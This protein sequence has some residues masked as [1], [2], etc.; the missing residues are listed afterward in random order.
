MPNGYFLANS[1]NIK[2]VFSGDLFARTRHKGCSGKDISSTVEE[3]FPL[4]DLSR[5]ED[6]GQCK[7]VQ[8][9]ATLFLPLEMGRGRGKK[10]FKN[11]V[12]LAYQNQG[13]ETELPRAREWRSFEQGCENW[14]T[15]MT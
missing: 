10:H 12:F 4:T 13:W 2:W 3:G 6:L 5:S 15:Q 9:H 11:V 7:G 14:R 1:E 8:L